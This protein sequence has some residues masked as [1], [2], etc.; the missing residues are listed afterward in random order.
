MAENYENEFI[1]LIYF[2][3]CS[4]ATWLSQATDALLSQL[5]AVVF[6]IFLG[7]IPNDGK[8]LAIGKFHLRFDN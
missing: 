6:V 4:L 3:F 2:S 8:I 5:I 1:L 7:K